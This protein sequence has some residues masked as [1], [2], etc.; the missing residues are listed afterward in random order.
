MQ[1]KSKDHLPQ[2]SDGIGLSQ[3][4]D[5]SSRAQLMAGVARVP[6]IVARVTVEQGISATTHALNDA[7]TGGDGRHIL[8]GYCE[9]NRRVYSRYLVAHILQLMGI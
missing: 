9:Y 5:N 6:V 8:T 3:L 7:G 4:D 1:N 2:R